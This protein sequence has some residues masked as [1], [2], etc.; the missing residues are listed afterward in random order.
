MCFV[1]FYLNLPFAKNYRKSNHPKQ[2]LDMERQFTALSMMVYNHFWESKVFLGKLKQLA[3]LSQGKEYDWHL[4]GRPK[5]TYTFIKDEIREI[6]NIESLKIYDIIKQ[7]YRSQIRN[8]FA[9]SDYYLSKKKIYLNN[10]DPK[11]TYT[12]EYIDYDEFDKIII[13]TLLIHHAMVSKID[14]YRKILGAEN[15]DR[16]IHVPENGGTKKTLQYRQSGSIYRWLWP[17]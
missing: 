10:Y 5:E 6:F 11:D 9:H 15:P 8:A 2:K 1:E 16:E 4:V 17:N 12:I 3:I 14:E 7:T 13:L